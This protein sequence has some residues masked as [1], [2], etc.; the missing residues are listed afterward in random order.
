M[1]PFKRS[2]AFGWVFLLP[3]RGDDH[4][5]C[6][7]LVQKDEVVQSLGAHLAKGAWLG[8]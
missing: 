5:R 8:I 2:P 1:A 6:P 7:V 3:M 4:A